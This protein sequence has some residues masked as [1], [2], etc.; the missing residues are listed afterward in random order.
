MRRS[1]S[2]MKFEKKAIDPDFAHSHFNHETDPT[3]CF[4]DLGG[5]V[6]RSHRLCGDAERHHICAGQGGPGIADEYFCA[7]GRMFRRAEFFPAQTAAGW[8]H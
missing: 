4:H 1:T 5:A 3:C 8:I 7:G 2:K 6:L